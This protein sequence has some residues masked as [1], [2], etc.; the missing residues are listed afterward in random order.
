MLLTH[1][2]SYFSSV[3]LRPN[4]S[5]YE[6]GDLLFR[7]QLAQTLELIANQGPDVFY[8]GHL[9]NLIVEEI[10]QFGKHFHNSTLHSMY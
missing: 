4:G 7:P 9:T 5:F 8:Q 2:N 6:A 10:K 3:Y 1:G